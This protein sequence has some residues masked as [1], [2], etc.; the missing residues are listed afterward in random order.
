MLIFLY[1]TY[2]MC[3]TF[4]YI[5]E[6][7]TA[8]VIFGK[9]SDREPDEAQN[10]VHFPQQHDAPSIQKTTFIEVETEKHR[11][12]VLLSKPFQLWGAEM[13]VN[14]HGVAI[15]NEAVFA[16]L[17]FE[18]KNT[19]LTG[20]DMLRLALEQATT[21]QLA[22]ETLIFYLEKY[23]QDA[24]GGYKDQKFFYHNAFLVADAHSA[25]VLETA[26]RFWA[27]QQIHKGF[28][29]ISNGLSIETHFDAISKGAIDFAWKKGW[30][31]KNADFNFKKAFS[32]FFMPRL[33][34][35][36]HRRKVSEHKAQV[37]KHFEVSS[38]F[39]IL[40]SHHNADNFIPQKATTKSICMH[41]S[42]LFC[43]HQTTGSMVAELR[44]NN[45]PTSVWLTGTSNPCISLFKPF[46]FGDTLLDENRFK[47]ATT[48]PDDSYWWTW[49]MRNRKAC[50]EHAYV[51]EKIHATQH[52]MEHEW[53]SRD[54]ELI[55]QQDQTALFHLSQQ[56]L[57]SSKKLLDL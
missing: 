51:V 34:A 33:A 8:S 32:Q 4:V 21:A 9:N 49:E 22:V 38:A 25:F 1:I 14:V 28:R 52:H 53:I 24:C 13:G 5:P 39:S 20:M 26:G 55:E 11:H 30:A 37:Y 40:R 44:A 19:G 3:D 29:A 10:I 35:C 15:G 18:R 57:E 48:L 27:Y 45:Q 7:R 41:S 23:G 6:S 56:A 42:G 46:Y 54:R 47:A 50:K 31:K 12:E 17:P 36:E 2:P 43:P 16:K